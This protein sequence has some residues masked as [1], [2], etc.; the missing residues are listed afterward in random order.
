MSWTICNLRLKSIPLF[1]DT[2]QVKQRINDSDIVTT[3]SSTAYD[4]NLIRTW[5]KYDRTRQSDSRSY[6]QSSAHGTDKYTIY[7]GRY[8][9]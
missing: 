5:L 4:N 7:I 3:W 8:V 9:Q 1:M 6:R 2:K